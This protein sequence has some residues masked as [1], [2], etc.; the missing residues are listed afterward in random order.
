MRR[1]SSR[2]SPSA[3]VAAS[4]DKGLLT[5]QQKGDYQLTVQGGGD[6]T[7]TYRIKI[8]SR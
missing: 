8:Q 5:L 4:S 6:A 2:T 1:R 7:G 3:S